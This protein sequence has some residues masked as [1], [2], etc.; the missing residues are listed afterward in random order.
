MSKVDMIVHWMLYVGSN[1]RQEYQDAQTK[2][3]ASI[4]KRVERQILIIKPDATPGTCS[5]HKR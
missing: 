4:K 5:S 2:Y 1:M 3:K